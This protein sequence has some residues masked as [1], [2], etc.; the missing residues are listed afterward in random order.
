MIERVMFANGNEKD[1]YT[2]KLLHI[3]THLYIFSF[4]VIVI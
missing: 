4:S 1:L 3:Q 2:I